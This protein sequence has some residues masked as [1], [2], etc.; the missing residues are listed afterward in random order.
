MEPESIFDDVYEQIPYPL[1]LQ[2]DQLVRELRK[3]ATVE[4]TQEEGKFPL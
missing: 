1:Q 3:G 4:Y 2:R